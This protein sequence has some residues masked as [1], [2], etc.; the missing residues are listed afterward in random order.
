VL[1]LYHKVIGYTIDDLK[2]IHSSVC[3]HRILIEGNHKP[4][5][6]HQKR[7]NPNMKVMVKKEMLKLLEAS[8]IYPISNSMCINLVQ[9]RPKKGRI[10]IVKNKNTVLNPTRTVMCWKICIDYRMLNKATHKAHFSLPFID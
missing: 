9:I 4:L 1:R 7:L 8:I 10:T 2:G 5:I 3:M 6:E